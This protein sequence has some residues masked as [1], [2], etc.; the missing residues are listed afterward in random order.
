[1]NKERNFTLLKYKTVPELKLELAKLNVELV[2]AF[3]SIEMHRYHVSEFRRDVK[4]NADPWAYWS[5]TKAKED[6]QYRN[7]VY[8]RA[9]SRIMRIEKLIKIKENAYKW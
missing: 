9:R 1:M 2:N 6:L 5:L 4:N 3:D 7:T 8:C